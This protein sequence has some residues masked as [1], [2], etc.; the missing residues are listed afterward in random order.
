MGLFSFIKNLGSKS[1]NKE[2]KV[3]TSEMAEV[4]DKRKASMLNEIISN[5]NLGV[6]NLSIDFANDVAT[7]YGQVSSTETKEKIILAL[8]NVAGV[9]GV[10]DRLSV[11]N[12]EPE[13]KMYEVQKGDSLSKIAKRFYGDP[14]KYKELFAANQP[15]LEDPNKIYPGQVLRIPNL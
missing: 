12:P 10:D 15:M 13:A 6:E 2:V 5:L 3:E 1:I 4:L 9:A 11:V 7:V 8:G 14:M